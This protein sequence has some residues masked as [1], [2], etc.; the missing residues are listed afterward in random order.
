VIY[1]S[2]IAAKMPPGVPPETAEVARDTLGGAVAVASELPPDVA[3]AVLAAARLAFV[4]GIHVV[5]A[6]TAIVALVAAIGAAKMLWTVPKRAETSD[7]AEAQAA[8]A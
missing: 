1:R 2:Q 6:I 8:P 4:E 5:A 7:P 3:A